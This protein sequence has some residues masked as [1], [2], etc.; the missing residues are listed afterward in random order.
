M[1][2]FRIHRMKDGPR[3]N[4]RWAPH[5]SG[6]AQVKPKDYELEVREIEAPHEYSAWAMLRESQQPLGIGDLL[7][8]ETGELSICKYVGFEKASW[9]ETDSHVTAAHVSE[10]LTESAP[11]HA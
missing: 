2:K 3:Q 5:V 10:A 7:E 1:P 4:F 6:A 8:R 11:V 9:L